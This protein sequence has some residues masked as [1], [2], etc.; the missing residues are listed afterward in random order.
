MIDGRGGETLVLMWTLSGVSLL[1][2]LLR[3]YTRVAIVRSIGADDYAYATA[4]VFFIL[5]TV[6]TH[7]SALYGFGQHIHTLSVDDA[8]SAV[9][10]EIMCQ[11]A[12][13][14]SMALAKISLALFLL[15]IV[16]VSWHKIAIW[17]SIISLSIISTSVSVVLW[18]QCRPVNKIWNRE[19]VEG[20]C[21]TPL[22]PV[23][24]T[25]G[26]WCVVVDFFLAIFLWLFIW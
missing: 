8:A 2:V 19:R 24:T 5:Y 15:R 23:A 4:G 12:A 22:T 20:I 13:V 7:I 14:I 11:A 10:W 17:T 25:L 16:V 21:D 1:M 18:T 6:F 9:F 3:M 26:S